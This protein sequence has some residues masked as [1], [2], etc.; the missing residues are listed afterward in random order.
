M[1][2]RRKDNMMARRK[3]NMMTRRKDMMPRQ[4]IHMMTRRIR[5]IICRQSS[6]WSPGPPTSFAA[7]R[8]GPLPLLSC[9]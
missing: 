4:P 5:G 8:G 6:T 9:G 1:M 3:D 2:A 7:R